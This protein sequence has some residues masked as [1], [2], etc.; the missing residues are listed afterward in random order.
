MASSGEISIEDA[1]ATFKSF[2]WRHFGYPVVTINGDRVTDKTRTICKH[3]KKISP[4]TSANT[5]TMHRHLQNHHRS[6]LDQ[7]ENPQNRHRPPRNHRKSLFK[8]AAVAVKAEPSRQTEPP[9]LPQLTDRA[10]EITRDIGIFIAADLTPFSVVENVGFKRLLN[11]LEPNYTIPTRGHF[12]HTVVPSLYKEC[13]TRVVQVL[14]DAESVAMTTEAWSFRGANMAEVLL[15]AVSEWE[16]KKPNRSIAIVTDDVDNTEVAVRQVGLEPQVQCFAHTVNLATRAGL[17]VTRVTALLGRMRRVISVFQSPTAAAV[18]KFKQKLLQLPCQAL[19]TDVRTRWNSTLDMLS[20]YLEQQA[21]IAG[22]L[23]SPDLGLNTQIDALDSN[24][25]R[26]TEDLVRLLDPLK[27]ATTV[28]CEEKS[29]PVS[30]I[31]PLKSMIEQS[32]TPNHDDSTT[33]A[34]TKRAILSNISGTYSG[35]IY[36]FLLECTALDPRFRTLPL[37]DGNQREAIFLRVQKKV[38]RLQTQTLAAKKTQQKAEEATPSHGENWDLK[39]ESELTEPASK[40]TALED[41]L[42]DSFSPEPECSNVSEQIRR[43][44]EH[45]RREAS[46]P[47]SSCPLRW[48]KEN[49]PQYPL[50]SP[51][52]KAYLSIPVTSVPSQRVFSAAGD[53]VNAQRSQLLPEHLDMLIFLNQN[54]TV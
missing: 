34:D 14:K 23:S 10:A 54:M 53:I 38:K 39:S 6:L 31:V 51:L 8:P 42:G 2:V 49:S 47:L 36:N 4:Y 12:S 19:S 50:L 35:D 17:G 37:L 27:T 52:A 16:L 18:L 41:L 30:L 20:R 44:I 48:W 13:K 21:A 43:E 15:E 29:P 11:T 45:Y 28:L 25:M 9:Q 33:V 32:M 40:K 1:P 24:D 26:D 5:S 22:A 3:C 7:H 46:I